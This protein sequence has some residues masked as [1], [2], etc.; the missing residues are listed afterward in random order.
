[1]KKVL[2]WFLVIAF[3]AVVA[4]VGVGYWIVATPGGAQLVLDRLAGAL[5]KGAKIEGVEGSLG[6]P[7]RV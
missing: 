4:I 1:M 2:R 5:G 3:V 6:G 7:L